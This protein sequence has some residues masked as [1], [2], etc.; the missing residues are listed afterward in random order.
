MWTKTDLNHA[1][2]VHRQNDA[3]TTIWF[4][5]VNLTAL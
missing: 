4:A 5:A 1:E 2:W 3:G